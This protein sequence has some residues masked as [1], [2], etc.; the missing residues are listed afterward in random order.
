MARR[1]YKTNEQ[2]KAE[3]KEY[4]RQYRLANLAYIR[5]RKAEYHL[6]T[7]DPDKARIDR[8]KRAKQHAEYC[9]RPEYRKWKKAYDRQR[10]ASEYGAFSE[11]FCLMMDLNREIKERMTNEQI[12]IAN[13]TW[14]KRQARAREGGETATRDRHRAAVG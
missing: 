12:R 4:D 7:Y 2:K 10:T 9:R 3:K 5:Q 6:R 8:K 13:G 14:A 1:K 11:A